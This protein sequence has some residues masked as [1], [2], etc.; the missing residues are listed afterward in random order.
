MGNSENSAEDVFDVERIVKDRMIKGKRQFLIKWV[1]YSESENTWEYE[2]NLMCADLVKAYFD[3][4]NN[5]E[6][7]TVSKRAK[8]QPEKQAEK[9]VEKQPEKKVEKL[10]EKK[11]EKMP[12]KKA[13]KLPEKKPE[14]TA[15][16]SKPQVKVSSEP[17]QGIVPLITNEWHDK[18]DKVVGASLLDNGLIEIEYVLKTGKNASSPSDVIKLKAPLKLIEFYEENLS[19]PE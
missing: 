9:K 12:E 13:E 3:E 7:Q 17:K 10:P 2:D 14:T 1:G 16:T 8:K 4:K 15:P 11:M 6:D 18:I 5:K 19:F